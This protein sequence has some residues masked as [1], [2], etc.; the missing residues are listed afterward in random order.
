MAAARS[1]LLGSLGLRFLFGLLY[2]IFV[3]LPGI[4]AVGG[5]HW[6]V[7]ETP[8]RFD[9]FRRQHLRIAAFGL[10]GKQ[11]AIPDIGQRVVLLLNVI[12][13]NLGHPRIVFHLFLAIL[14]DCIPVVR[15][16][17]S[18]GGLGVFLQVFR[19]TGFVY[20]LRGAVVDEPSHQKKD[21]AENR[22]L[23]VLRKKSFEAVFTKAN[24]E[25]HRR[26]SQKTIITPFGPS[27]TDDASPEYQ[28]LAEPDRSIPLLETV[29]FPACLGQRDCR[30]R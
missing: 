6:D 29:R 3:I 23:G 26:F 17:R 22:L 28:S 15:V 30:C 12:A 4:T 21:Q 11:D 19:R 27:C 5:P 20:V 10:R 14:F 16:E 2:R 24:S 1:V 8:R 25:P 18:L 7:E 13:C 9:Y